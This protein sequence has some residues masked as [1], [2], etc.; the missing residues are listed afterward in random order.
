MRKSCQRLRALQN[1]TMDTRVL[2]ALCHEINSSWA[3][4]N[5]VATALVM[6]AVLNYVP[7]AFGHE[8]FAQVLAQSPRTLKDSWTHLEEGL[9]KIADFHTHRRL[10]RSDM[11]PSVGQVEP[12]RP[13]FELLLQ[14]TIARLAVA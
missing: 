8:A 7:P 3:H 1:A 10:G 14:E 4:G 9:R 13:Q 11:Y 5:I 2:V 6:R 12:F